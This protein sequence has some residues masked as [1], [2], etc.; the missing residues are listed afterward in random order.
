G[1]SGI[2]T[3]VAGNSCRTASR[4]HKSVCEKRLGST[5]EPRLLP[6]VPAKQHPSATVP[7]SC[8]NWSCPVLSGPT[9]ETDMKKALLLATVLGLFGAPVLAQQSPTGQSS[10]GPA[11]A[12]TPGQ[13]TA[14]APGGAVAPGDTSTK[15]ATPTAPQR[16]KTKKA[17]TPKKAKKAT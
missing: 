10:G 5:Q 3:V 15:A 14:P 9:Q 7:V 13:V 12:G 4:P 1:N 11:R 16:A 17:K 6:R 2:S 8:A